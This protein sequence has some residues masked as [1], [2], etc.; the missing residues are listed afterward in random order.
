MSAGE[1]AMAL[2]MTVGR[3][4]AART[5]AEL[6]GLDGED[7]V[8]DVGCGPG[9]AVRVAARQAREAIGI[10]PSRV[11]LR[12]ARWITRLRRVRR[13][14]WLEG[15]AEFLPLEQGRLTVAWAVS[16]V[17]HW[18]DRVA[19]LG[20]IHRVLVPGGRIVLAERL[21]EDGARGHAAHG[22]TS[23]QAATLASEMGSAGFSGVQIG[24]CDARRRTLVVVR[25]V[26]DA[27]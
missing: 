17:H 21:V 15:V 16:S 9:T 26:R 18:E 23:G 20:E 27:G 5:V 19:A 8:V 1:I 6:A 3:G 24:R 4:A 22:L 14:T 13:V 12:L 10:D 25:G 11:S 7:R 2:S